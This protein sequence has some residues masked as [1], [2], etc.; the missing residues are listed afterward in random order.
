MHDPNDPRAVLDALEDI[1]PQIGQRLRASVFIGRQVVAA[2]PHVGSLALS[3]HFQ[4]IVARQMAVEFPRQDDP[5]ADGYIL[6]LDD[7]RLRF[8]K[9]GGGGIPYYNTTHAAQNLAQGILFSSGVEGAE[10][11]EKPI[12]QVSWEFE[13]GLAEFPV[14]H[15]LRVERKKR[16]WILP[17]ATALQFGI[18]NDAPGVEFTDGPDIGGIA[19]DETG[20]ADGR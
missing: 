13:N 2:D 9:L 12:I 15:L 17:F 4:D 8:N 3:T 16:Q 11:E 1:L 19:G 14:F 6:V 5:T 20:E 10:G 18:S 7:F